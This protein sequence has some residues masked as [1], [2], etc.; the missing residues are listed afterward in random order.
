MSFP[1]GRVQT[2]QALILIDICISCHKN[3][4]LE[5]LDLLANDV[6]KSAYKIIESKGATYYAIAESVKKI[7]SSIVKD[8]NTVLP[9]SSL[10]EGHY[11]LDDICLGLPSIEG[12]SGV[13]E[14]LD[15]PLNDIEKEMLRTSARKIKA[16]V[17]SLD[18][19]HTM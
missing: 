10:V 17:D 9:V 3:C 1:Y 19:A 11:G 16:I 5:A 13:K 18:F 6:K 15:I 2:F 4:S 12:R 8:E 7:V 14:I